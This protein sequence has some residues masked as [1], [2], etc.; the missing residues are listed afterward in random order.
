MEFPANALGA[1]LDRA[2]VSLADG[3]D[4]GAVA[5]GLRAAGGQVFTKDQWVRHTL[6]EVTRTTW[7][8]LLR[9]V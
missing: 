9:P 5:A 3:A 6:P 7:L 8:S 1:R 4:A 2:D